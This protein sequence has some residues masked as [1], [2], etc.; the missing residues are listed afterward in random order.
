MLEDNPARPGR[1]LVW[2]KLARISALPTAISNVL[3][4]FLI[5]NGTWSPVPELVLLLLASSCLYIAGMILNDVYDVEIDRK[6]RPSRPL[7][8]GAI[9]VGAARNTGYGLLF[10]GIISAFAAGLIG[11]AE[12]QA[13]DVRPPVIAFI[14]AVAIVLYDGVLK[15]TF[16]ACPL[17]GS[18]RALNICLAA[19]TCE[20][21]AQSQLVLPIRIW[22][23]AFAI[24]VLITGVTWFARNETG[25][26]TLGVML[27]PACV[28]FAGLVAY[29]VIPQ[30]DREHY[31]DR[32]ANLFLLLIL[33]LSAPVVR[34]VC[35]ALAS[36][37][38]R[39]VQQAIISVLRSLIILDA[40][41]C[42][43]V[44]DGPYYAIAVLCLLIPSYL[45]SKLV[46]K[47]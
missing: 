30:F 12:G 40:A 38:P 7:P 5:A 19:S 33:L 39:H 22:W 2:L 11:A 17:M 14:L 3:M 9:S 18:C 47:T 21:A 44:P 35:T 20:I 37:T 10:A 32:F 27:V 8:S 15:K 25:Q 46:S 6:E 36:G 4:A 45:L 41:V 28:I 43:L 42:V 13:L 31:V 29:A 26:S 1:L 23:I 34:R 16:L 24:F